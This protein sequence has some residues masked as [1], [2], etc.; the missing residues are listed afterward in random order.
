VNKQA[1]RFAALIALTLTLTACVSSPTLKGSALRKAALTDC[2]SKFLAEDVAP[3][4][5]LHIC[6]SIYSRWEPTTTGGM[7]RGTSND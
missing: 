2:V 7:S 4:D 6:S 1:S 3:V 5:S